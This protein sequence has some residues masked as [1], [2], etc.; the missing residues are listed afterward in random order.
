MKQDRLNLIKKIF[1][2]K[3]I[4]Q[5]KDVSEKLPLTQA[6]LIRLFKQLGVLTSFN[7]KGQ[8]YILPSQHQFSE[9]KLLFIGD[10]GFYKEGNL[11]NAI[12][13]L[14]EIS[15]I[16][17]GARELDFM[18]KTTT[19]SQLPALYRKGLLQRELSGRPGK[20]YVYF[21]LDTEKAKQQRD[22]FFAP[23]IEPVEPPSS[24]EFPDVIEVLLSL[25]SHPDFTAKSVSISLQRQGKKVTKDFVEKVFEF[26]GLSKK[27][28]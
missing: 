14:V 3:K 9:N 23:I 2:K 22:S 28:R 16:G 15:P 21:S 4:V 26:Y 6:S 5:L 12:C 25:I 20:S 7:C 13:H 19:H 24:E 1:N 11:L 27:K 10:V 17:L 18:L 8:F